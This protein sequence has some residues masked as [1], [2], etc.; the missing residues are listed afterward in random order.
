VS[1]PSPGFVVPVGLFAFGNRAGPRPPRIGIDLIPD[2]AGN[3]GPE[4]PP[5]PAGASTFA[6]PLQA[7]LTGHYHGLVRGTP[8]P[9]GL[10][11]VADGSDVRADSPHPPG[12]HTIYPAVEMPADQFVRLFL[13]L[14]WLWVGRK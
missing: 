5:F 3:V 12:H 13:S 1:S 10:G 2:A 7:P 4:A 14:P 6:D 8:L 9:A 11:V